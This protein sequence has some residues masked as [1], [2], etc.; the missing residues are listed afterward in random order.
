MICNYKIYS[1]S[2]NICKAAWCTSFIRK[3][4]ICCH[5]L[6]SRNYNLVQSSYVQ[7]VCHHCIFISL[8]FNCLEDR[9]GKMCTHCSS[10]GVEI[11]L[12][13]SQ[14]NVINRIFKIFYDAKTFVK[15]FFL[16]FLA[17]TNKRFSNNISHPY[18][19]KWESQML[20]LYF[21]LSVRLCNKSKHQ[22]GWHGWGQER[23]K[24]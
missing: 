8:D 3:S 21:F 19:G 10:Q 4:S 16:V 2:Y 11:H 13:L 9:A 17:L 15:W 18:V 6:S 24:H 23:R 14:R 5:K 22:V 7:R 12:Y 20:F 1:I